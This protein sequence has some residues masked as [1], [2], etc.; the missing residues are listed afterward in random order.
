MPC[1]VVNS[2]AQLAARLPSLPQ[3]MPTTQAGWT[4]FLNALNA[5]LQLL[6][7]EQH[8]PNVL[9]ALFQTFPVSAAA[10]AVAALTAT[11]CTPSV[12][13]TEQYYGA[14]SLKVA[15]S[16]TG[17]TLTFTGNP[18]AIAAASRWFCAFQVLAASGVTG[19]LTVSTSGGHSITE[20]F[21]VAASAAWQQVWG[22]FDFRAYPDTQAT[23]EFMF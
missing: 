3:Q 19:S 17:A 5:S 21:T 4:A 15:I 9:P 22:L 1:Q 12:D 7:Q 18:I 10:A 23:W 6:K 8:A 20:S 14:A 13:N 11:S 2:Q 16:A